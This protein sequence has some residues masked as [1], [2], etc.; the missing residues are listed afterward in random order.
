MTPYIPRTVWVS[1]APKPWV[2]TA[3][4]P[5]HRVYKQGSLSWT[6]REILN[7]INVH[8]GT[9]AV[10][11]RAILGIAS[12]SRQLRCLSNDG[13]IKITFHKNIAGKPFMRCWPNDFSTSTST[14]EANHYEED[15]LRR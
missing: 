4:R 10:D 15:Y 11:V 12:I 5:E 2:P 8:P 3:S 1:S 6:A 9:K 13:L 7:Y 14:F